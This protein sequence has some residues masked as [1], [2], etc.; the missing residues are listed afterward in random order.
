[1][2]SLG[3]RVRAARLV[4]AGFPAVCA[5][6]FLVS[7]FDGSR[8]VEAFWEERSEQRYLGVWQ[9]QAE[10]VTWEACRL[11]PDLCPGKIVVWE[12]LRPSK[13]LTCA[14]GNCSRRVS[15]TNE[16][17]VPVTPGRGIMTVVA[18]VHRVEPGSVVLVFLGSPEAPYGGTTRRSI[19]SF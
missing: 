10:A 19:G 8:V 7:W 4:L 6:V 11:Q 12:V 2:S 18:R 15:W 1:M 16:D 9:R 17:Q 13:G 5:A 14:D 3:G